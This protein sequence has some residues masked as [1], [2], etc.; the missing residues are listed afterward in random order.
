MKGTVSCVQEPEQEA[1]TKTKGREEEPSSHPT[2]FEINLE[3]P[4]PI[5][6]AFSIC[7]HQSCAVSLV[8]SLTAP[9]NKC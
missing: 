2:A 9:Q 4:G 5:F 7:L 6:K 8:S 3:F 1:K